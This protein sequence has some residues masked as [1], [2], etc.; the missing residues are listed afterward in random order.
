MI[1]ST[2]AARAL[3][4]PRSIAIIGDTPTGGRG[5]LLHE[6]LVRRGFDGE[7][8]PVNPNYDEVRGC[9]AYPT[10]SAYGAPVDF[11]AVTLGPAQ[12]V[13]CMR[14]SAAA[15]ARAVLFIG[16]GFAEVGGEGAEIQQEIVD[17]ARR[18]GVALAGPNCYGFANVRGR[19]APFFGALPSPLVAGP[20]AL[21]FGSGALTHAVGDVLA[22][23]GAGLGYVVT[24]GNEAGVDAADYVALIADD[25]EIRVI[26][27]YLETIR[28]PTSFAAAARKAA[29]AG[30][31]LV[32][33]S[34]GRSQESRHATTAHTGALAGEARVVAAF[35]GDLGAIVV[36]DLDEL[37]EV[38]ELSTYVQR[39]GA[40]PVAITAISGGGCAVLADLCADAGLTLTTFSPSVLDALQAAIPG[41]GSIGNPV[42]LTGLATDDDTIL[43]KALHAIDSEPSA[44]TGLQLFAVNTPSAATEADRELYRNMTRT[45]ART[46]AELR[47]PVGLMT[48][49]SG[50][51]DLE[52]VGIAH[53]AG[54]PV[55]QG[56]R[57][58]VGAVARMRRSTLRPARAGRA[59]SPDAF[60]AARAAARLLT[61]SSGTVP[62]PTVAAEIL[63]TAGVPVAA[64]RVVSTPGEAV[65]VAEQLGYP[66]VAK[67]ESPDIVHKSD[68]GCV[69][70]DLRSPHD[71]ET[72]AK[73]ILARGAELGVRVDGVR[74]EK[75]VAEGVAVLLG[76]IVDPQLGPALAIG[77]GGIYTELLDD[78]AVLLAP[79]TSDEVRDAIGALRISR[80]LAGMRGQRAADVDALVSTAVALSE[81]AWVARS[82][83]AAV[84]VNPVIVHERGAGVTAVDAVVLRS[85]GAPAT[86]GAP[87]AG[88]E[89]S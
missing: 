37:V 60:P 54:L 68:A 70:L 86:T 63:R 24:V 52:L 64:G 65:E 55:L 22:A 72:A 84:D 6:Q 38:V 67:I 44:D 10:V 73:T 51:L 80:L 25:P 1:P 5:G 83:L 19:F 15:G 7:I 59:R 43:A 42:D 88:K 57:E 30:Q 41:T 20:V 56:A 76:A 23:R 62:T 39:V 71:V 53:R 79:A 82:Q 58:S 81:F 32:V 77:A 89:S 48:L 17:I 34:V 18:R 28:N 50:Q 8:I 74:V 13:E 49:T 87:P 2:E 69:L 16:S 75:Q 3:L 45:V 12:A 29:D 40:G 78:A 36:H 85:S 35:L 47:T 66:V 4:R 9:R 61:S 33:L 26:A 27:C 14:D 11:T 21:V 31:Q 46:A